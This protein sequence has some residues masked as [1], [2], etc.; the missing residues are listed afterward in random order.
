MK[1]ARHPKLGKSHQKLV[2]FDMFRQHVLNL[3]FG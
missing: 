3:R 1:K 2:V